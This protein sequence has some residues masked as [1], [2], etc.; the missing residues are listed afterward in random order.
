MDTNAYWIDRGKIYFDQ[1]RR[2]NPISKFRFRIQEE[3]LM[4]LLHKYEFRSVLEIGC[5]YGRITKKIL[6]DKNFSINKY[7]ATDISIDQVNKA[8]DL[9]QD[10]RVQWKLQNV[11]DFDYDEEFDLVL[12]SEVFMHIKPDKIGDV[13]NKSLDASRNIVVNIDWCRPT[14]PLEIGGFCFQHD[15]EKLYKD[16]YLESV[17]IW[18]K[19][20]LR[21]SIFVAGV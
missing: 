5:G 9:V 19:R 18:P 4:R 1:H 15:Y 2:L 20:L 14:E 3:S 16:Y 6:N 10:D 12:A 21:Q 11:L 7:L 17:D 13:I 8:K